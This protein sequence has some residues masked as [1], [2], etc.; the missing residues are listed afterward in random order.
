MI[1]PISLEKILFAGIDAV[2]PATLFP[3][4]LINPYPEL[5]DWLES[6]DRYLLCIGK[7]GISSAKSILDLAPCKN[8]YIVA[9]EST[10]AT[11]FTVHF[12]SHP[13]PNEK[14]LRAGEQLLDWLKRIPTNSRLMIILSGG[15]SALA[16]APAPGI[17]LQ[18]KMMV[19]DLLIRSG[20]TIQE[21]NTVR[22]HLS[23]IKGGQ[24]GRIVEALHCVV[25]VI[26][27]VI[28]NDLATIGS[29]PFFPDPTTFADARNVLGKYDLWN[30]VPEEVR[31]LLD[32]GVQGKLAE[33]P[34]PGSYREIPHY[35]I[36]SN[37]IARMAA[38]EESRKLRFQ[39]N[40]IPDAI[41][42][43]IDQVASGIASQIASA[44]TNSA[45]ILG[46][47]VTVHV[48]GNGT[49]GRNQHLALLLT[50]PIAG[51]KILFC[52]AGTDGIDGNSPAAGAWI[53]GT[54][55]RT[56]QDSRSRS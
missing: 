13:L 21:I 10:E 14:S 37:E 9:P 36:A 45:I 33:T 35:I 27:D 8:Y 19:N 23:R 46:G 20:A 49:G 1:L 41:S 53:D 12:G 44:P 47:E 43:P 38:T 30:R 11:P 15:S 31:L 32:R 54:T 5:K 18:S 29:G 34:K 22:K 3:K 39:S 56:V 2:R 50:E 48:Q 24:L 28:G 16:V 25:L 26:S 6:D 42:G 17:S 51:K 4:I 52:A 7:A 40:Y 55:L